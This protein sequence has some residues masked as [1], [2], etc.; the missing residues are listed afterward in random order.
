MFASP[1]QNGFERFRAK[2]DTIKKWLGMGN[3]SHLS[4]LCDYSHSFFIFF[5]LVYMVHILQNRGYISIFSLYYSISPD[6]CCR[7][8]CN[9]GKRIME[10]GLEVLLFYLYLTA[11]R[12]PTTFTCPSVGR[13]LPFVSIFTY[14]PNSFSTAITYCFRRQ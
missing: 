10:S 13:C 7:R 4:V 3:P 11:H 2:R 1:L 5:C 12:A 6:S 8:C 14:P 9:S